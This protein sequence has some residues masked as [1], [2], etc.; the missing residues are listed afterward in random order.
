MKK[1][2]KYAYHIFARSMCFTLRYCGNDKWT[3]RIF[4]GR[5]TFHASASTFLHRSQP[6][7]WQK[8]NALWQKEAAIAWL[9]TWIVKYGKGWLNTPLR[10]ERV[11][12]Q[13]CHN[14]SRVFTTPS[15][16][17]R[18]TGIK[19]NPRWIGGSVAYL[20]LSLPPSLPLSL[21]FSLSLRLNF[22]LD[23]CQRALPVSAITS[24]GN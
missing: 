22:R 8:R 1:E 16:Q 15:G 23:R 10:G 7:Y 3:F 13:V 6:E 18:L 9:L 12:M 4:R 17:N 11:Q 20:S 5:N 21:F 19:L 14:R 2:Q 24:T